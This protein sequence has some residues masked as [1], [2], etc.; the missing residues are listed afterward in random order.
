MAGSLS[1]LI[2]RSGETAGDYF[3]FLAAGF[4]LVAL[5]TLAFFAIMLIIYCGLTRL[6]HGSFSGG[7]GIMVAG[8]AIVNDSYL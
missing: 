2:F 7:R 4:F 1:L 6:R 8:G 5:L 3:F